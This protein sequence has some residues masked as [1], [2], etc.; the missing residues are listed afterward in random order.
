MITSVITSQ[1]GIK[2]V[3]LQHLIPIQFFGRWCTR[4]LAELIMSLVRFLNNR[5]KSMPVPP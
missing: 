5:F 3:Y 2:R 1:G 4:A